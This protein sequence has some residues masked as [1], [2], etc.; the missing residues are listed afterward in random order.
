[1]FMTRMDAV[2]PTKQN[3]I[4]SIF[5]TH[6][7]NKIVGVFAFLI[8]LG[9]FYI[10]QIN[11]LAV[12]GYEVKDGEKENARLQKEVTQLQIDVEKMKMADNLQA[13]IQ[14]LN[15]VQSKNVSYVYASDNGLAMASEI[16]K[17]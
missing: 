16:S 10:F 1:M 2:R 4:S 11:Q 15:M 6:A 12:L 7:N 8:V 13:K 5:G 14:D 9:G 17:Y 3:K